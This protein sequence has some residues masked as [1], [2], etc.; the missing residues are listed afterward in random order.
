MIAALFERAGVDYAQWKAVSRVLLRADFRAPYSRQGESYALDRARGWL[1]MALVYGLFGASAALLIA[2]NPDVRL[3]GTA[4]LTY[5]TFVLATAVLTQHGATMLSATDDLVLA[6]RPVSSRTFLVIRLTNVLFHGLLLTTF[7][8]YPPIIA[9]T[10]AH[11]GSIARGVAA[12]LAIYAW[13]IALTMLLAAGYGALLAYVPA[14]RVQRVVGYV[15]LVVGAMAYG[16]FMIVMRA[17]GRDALAAATLPAGPWWYLWPPAWFAS[18]VVMASGEATAGDVVAVVLSLVLV[19]GTSWWLLV[20]LGAGYGR[21][22][23]Q[24]PVTVSAPP[25]ASLPP[26]ALRGVRDDEARAV[27]RLV[28]AHFKHDLRV[29]MSILAIVPLALLYLVLGATNPSDNNPFRT[30]P[31]HGEVVFD[32]MA[33]TVLIFPAILMQHLGSS[34]S[35]KAAW[36][37]DV[38]P[39]DRRRLVTALKDV[40]AAYFLLPFV[41]LLTLLYSWQFRHVGHGSTHALLLGGVSYIALQTSVI[42][43]PRLPFALPPR[44]AVDSAAIFAWMLGVMVGGQLLLMVMRDWVYQSWTRVGAMAILLTLVAAALEPLVRR[45]GARAHDPDAAV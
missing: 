40:S 45:R 8:A 39:V 43:S 5:L 17:I 24:L 34:E 30:A 33:F 42:A 37:F 22:L 35:Y 14:P 12:T 11:G 16:G 13:A 44:K 36:V 31:G 15:Q 9:F 38:A 6:P 3:T 28:I 4:T 23:A 19:A 10:V 41:A 25:V 29:R 7:M 1:M 26:V 32:Y 21:S 18:Y 20:K 27:A 2:I